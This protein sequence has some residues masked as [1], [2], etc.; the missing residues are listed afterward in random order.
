MGLQLG[1][2]VADDIGGMKR[3]ALAFGALGV[4][5]FSALAG[6]SA[7]AQQPSYPPGSRL[8]LFAEPDEVQ[9]NA[10]F[11]AILTGCFPGE[12]VTFFNFNPYQQAQAICDATTYTA[13]VEF[14]A[15]ATTGTR[16]ISAFIPALNSTDPDVPSLP[17]RII[18][19]RYSVVTTIVIVPITGDNDG[20]STSKVS[21]PSSSDWWPS[22][23]S[24]SAILRTFL[25]L[26]ALLAGFFFVLAWRRRRDEEEQTQPYPGRIIPPTD[27][28]TAT[29]A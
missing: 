9:T 23:L 1:I 12:T 26:L 28:P 5:C 11:D 10:V 16:F 25:G 20:I 15:S 19:A 13:M 2:D 14:T 22:F 29:L 24:S 3:L 7:Q 21:P 17:P 18:F 6:G 27:P 4:L 8:T